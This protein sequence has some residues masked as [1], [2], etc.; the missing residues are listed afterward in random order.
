MGGMNGIRSQK[1]N[2]MKHCTGVLPCD[3]KINSRPKMNKENLKEL[4]RTILAALFMV[5]TVYFCFLAAA[6]APEPDAPEPVA[7]NEGG[8]HAGFH[9]VA[10]RRQSHP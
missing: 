2:V 9:P 6:T 7:R 1:G 10:A 8:A 3:L 4:A 5:I